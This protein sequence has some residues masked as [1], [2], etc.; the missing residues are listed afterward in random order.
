MNIPAEYKKGG[1][2]YIYQEQV[3]EYQCRYKEKKFGWTECFLIQ[4]LI[5][6]KDIKKNDDGVEYEI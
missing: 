1:R 5:K 2:T 4:D 3:N 6:I